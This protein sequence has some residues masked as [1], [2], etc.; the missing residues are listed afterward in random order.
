[1]ILFWYTLFALVA[2]GINLGTQ[3]LTIQLYQGPFFL[4]L[5]MG[6]GT[7]SGL[8]AKYLLD[9]RFIFR[10]QTRSLQDDARKFL[11]YSAMGLITTALFWAMELLF[12]HFIDH[13]GAKYLGGAIGLGLGYLI[14]YHLDKR[15]VFRHAP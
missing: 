12:H 1:M 15:F 2:T 7:G 8:V 10:F 6:T 13:P 4:Y 5:A 11:L 3:W 9:K 14:K